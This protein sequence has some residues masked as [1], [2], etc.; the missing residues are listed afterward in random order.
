MLKRGSCWPFLSP[1]PQLF[2]PACAILFF[3][4][5]SRLV[6]DLYQQCLAK[7]DKVAASQTGQHV[8]SLSDS[9]LHVSCKKT[10]W[11]TWD[12]VGY[13][14][15][16]GISSLSFIHR[17]ISVARWVFVTFLLPL[18]CH[19]CQHFATTSSQ[20]LAPPFIFLSLP[21]SAL[22]TSVC[23]GNHL[24]C[25]RRPYLDTIRASFPPTPS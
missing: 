19:I 5:S 4:V 7:I 25:H 1:H 22:P 15:N 21:R 14:P 24:C 10:T 2:A 11:S 6:K 13:L 17:F 8:I 18:L 20:I 23:A 9:I 3:L 16:L 12:N